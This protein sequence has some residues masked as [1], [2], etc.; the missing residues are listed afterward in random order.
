MCQQQKKYTGIMNRFFLTIFL[1]VVIS[2]LKSQTI[3][4]D[5]QDTAKWVTINRTVSLLNEDG[6][7]G[8]YFKET[9]GNGLMVLK[10]IE[11]SNGAI[12]FDVKGKNLMQQSFVGI[13]FH[14]QNV[15]TYDAVYFRPFNFKSPD[16]IRRAHSV[17]Y[18]SMPDNDWEKLR[19]QFPGKFENTV[20]PVPDPEEWFH[21]RLVVDGKKVSVFV[22]HSVTPSLQVEKLTNTHRGGV[23]LWMGNN[24][25]GSF[26]N[27][28][29]TPTNTT[30]SGS[31]SYGNNPEAG[32]YLNAGD[33]R[34]YYEVYGQGKPLVMLHGGVYGYID[35][36]QQF[37]ERLS[38][39][40]QVICIAT[41]GHGKSEAGKGDFS[42]QQRAEDAYKLIRHIT[43]DSV[44]VLGFS[45]GGY[46]AFRLAALH[47][48]LV[49][50]LIVIGAG[51]Y[52]T[53]SK[54][55]KFNYTPEGLMK[56]DSAFFKSRLALMP[57]PQ[58]WK[59]ILSKLSKMYN[60]DATSVEIFKKITC[61]TLVMSGDRDDYLSVEA[62]VNCA[63][64]IPN[65]QLSIIPNCHH[66]VFFCNFPAVWE[67]INPF[68]KN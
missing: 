34:L 53:N 11:F 50:K 23:A 42:F 25:G 6:R 26:A 64:A 43:R 15:T 12:E 66:V 3:V 14:G 57:E 33:A 52:P 30:A 65:A 8:I 39:N 51:D 27:L 24:S 20:T 4:P 44:I 38:Q 37:I 35:E 2:Q 16:S 59:E 32:K 40:Y 31:V 61:P 62:V 55:Q 46:S 22:N 45:D 60:E 1:G 9:P 56:Y 19:T 21:V 67:A 63:K 18:I 58:R 48:E 36:Y 10:G 5:L 41:R 47:P 49:N 54:R 68:L 28:V 29:I 13:A 17:Q 7:K